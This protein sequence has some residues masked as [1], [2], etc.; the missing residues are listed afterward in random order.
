MRRQSKKKSAGKKSA[1]K[2]R[3]KNTVPEIKTSHVRGTNRI[4][5]ELSKGRKD[6]EAT[7]AALIAFDWN[8]TNYL[9][10]KN[11]P[12]GRNYKPPRGFT[13]IIKVEKGGQTYHFSRVSP[14]DMVVNKRNIAEF[15]A[16]VLEE[17]SESWK[18]AKDSI[19]EAREN[20]EEPED[21][22]GKPA[23]YVEKVDPKY[24][25]D[26]AIHFFY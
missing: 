13:V 8:K 3:V 21:I 23:E 26:I 20:D 4:T 9:R 18:S 25:T 2:R 14:V 12:N 11:K 17:L 5:L 6:I 19:K 24:I 15:T 10:R 1:Q 16:A 7:E 22:D